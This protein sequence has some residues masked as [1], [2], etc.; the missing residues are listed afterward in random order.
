MILGN[1]YYSDDDDNGDYLN[2]IFVRFYRKTQSVGFMH[3]IS[4]LSVSD[5]GLICR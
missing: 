5:I 4:A 3:I 2:Y 1:Y